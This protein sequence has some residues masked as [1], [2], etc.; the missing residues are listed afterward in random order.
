[1]KQGVRSAWA[2]LRNTKQKLA[3]AGT[4]LQPP[5][6]PPGPILFLIGTRYRHQCQAQ[7]RGSGPQAWHGTDQATSHGFRR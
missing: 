7:C 1:M 4:A 6:P 2:T 3:L 5:V